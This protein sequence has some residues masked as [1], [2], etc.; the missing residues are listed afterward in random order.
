MA[1]TRRDDDDRPRRRRWE[2]DRD[3]DSPRR[4]E[5]SGSGLPLLLLGLFGCGGFLLLLVVG[6]LIFV[7]IGR[8]TA[9]RMEA[10]AV[11]VEQAGPPMAQQAEA[12]PRPEVPGGPLPAK[13]DPATVT[14]VKDSTVYL[15][16]RLPNGGVAQGSGF[17]CLE[18][19]IIVTNAHVLGMLRPD[20]AAPRTVDVVV[21]SGEANELK[22]T[23]SVLAVDRTNDLA[24]LRAAGDAGR[25]PPPLAVG[26]AEKLVETQSVY[27]FGFP[28]GAD[29]GKNITVS[30]SSV[31]SLR[32]DQ[33]GA[34]TQVQVNGGMHP[35][36][37]GGPVADARG[38]VVGVSVAIIQGTQINFAI[39]GEFVTRL[40]DGKSAGT[41]LGAPYRGDG[42][43]M[44]PVRLNCLDPLGRLRDV[45]VEVWAGNPGNPRPAGSRD[46]AP[47]PGDGPRQSYPLAPADG[48]CKGDVPLPELKPGQVCWLQPVFVNAAGARQWDAAT[49]VPQ[50]AQTVLD[51][52]PAVIQ[53]LAPANAI[54]RTLK[55]NSTFTAN[56]Y[57]GKAKAVTVTRKLD[58][59]VLES[60]SPDVRGIGT[61]SR[62]TIGKC[63]DNR[64]PPGKNGPVPAQAYTLLSQYSPTFLVDAGHALK[65][66]GNRDFRVIPQQYRDSVEGI[67]EMVCNTYEA[68]TLPVP[69][70]VVRPAESWPAQVPMLVLAEGKRSIQHLHL[71]C[72][73]E[74][75]RSVGG[76]NEAFIA[77]S[78]VAKGRAPRAEELGKVKGH[79]L[80]DVEKGF[81]TLVRLT[82]NSELEDEDEGLRIL[83]SKELVVNRA[84]GNT[85][86]IT[87]AKVNQPGAK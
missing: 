31:S 14:R 65:E 29:L 18:P 8:A 44:L 30:E 53:F 2:D 7:F 37:S 35:G 22:T 26:S 46:P 59:D 49:P 85:Q 13:I 84:E 60:L 43:V 83:V 48:T 78:G 4:E 21:H 58:G 87:P 28:L 52:K 79:A 55:L 56:V 82:V 64:D 9:V 20:A 67:Y 42:G 47:Q 23:A 12:P 19:G 86:G 27:V 17:L 68:T 73:Y 36:N 61:L 39:P 32:R 15:R 51:R 76:R 62:L 45:K 75:L 74:G 34:L 70:R 38:A 57:R 81:F 69:N 54:E 6:G 66:R 41:E 63:V 72:T 77:V 3:D 40:L 5:S 24:V 11:A 16:V 80:L 71:T 25:L 50:D 1:R 10:E 33:S